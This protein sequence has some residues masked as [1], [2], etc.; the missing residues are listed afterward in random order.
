V[1]SQLGPV[2]ADSV[3]A[4][5]SPGGSALPARGFLSERLRAVQAA[6]AG[7]AL[8]GTLLLATG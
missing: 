4:Y 2:T 1:G 8:V 5:L 7:L 6:G 3:L